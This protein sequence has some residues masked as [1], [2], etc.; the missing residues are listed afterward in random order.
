MLGGKIEINQFQNHIDHTY[1]N[2]HW[3]QSEWQRIKKDILE[4]LKTSHNKQSTPLE[5]DCLS[6]MF[7][8]FKCHRFTP[9][10]YRKK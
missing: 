8:P 2:G 3:V 6:C 9:Y 7:G 10:C 5:N 1:P 4:V